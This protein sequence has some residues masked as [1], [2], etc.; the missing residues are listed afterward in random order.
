M[1]YIKKNHSPTIVK[2]R[3]LDIY[4]NSK[5]L[6]VYQINDDKLDKKNEKELQKL[7]SKSIGNYDLTIVSDYGHGF[8]SENIAKI[9][10]KKS[11]F[12]A[13]NAQINAANVEYARQ[14]NH[15]YIFEVSL[16]FSDVKTP[17]NLEI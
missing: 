17:K 13:L 11:N 7:I 16:I 2:K 9:I 14:L 12:V 5:V 8:I 10:S 3:F 4:S 1:S 15:L 6:G